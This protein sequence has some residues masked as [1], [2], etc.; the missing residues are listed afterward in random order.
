[1][2]RTLASATALVAVLVVAVV[3]Y[4]LLPKVPKPLG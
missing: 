4:S 3:G 1:M 2:N